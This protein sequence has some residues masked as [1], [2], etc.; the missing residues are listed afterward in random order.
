MSNLTQGQSLEYIHLIKNYDLLTLSYQNEDTIALFDINNKYEI[1]VNPLLKQSLVENCSAYS[2][3][4]N[5][6]EELMLIPAS[7]FAD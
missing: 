1:E 3:K 6:L 7:N 2:N 5:L 4:S